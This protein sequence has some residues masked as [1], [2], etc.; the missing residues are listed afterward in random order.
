MFYTRLVFVNI[1]S[2]LE[3]EIPDQFI[4]LTDIWWSPIKYV[5]SN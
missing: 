1:A 2:V 4:R 5:I 3:V